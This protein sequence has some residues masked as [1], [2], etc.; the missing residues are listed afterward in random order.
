VFA[1]VLL[2]HGPWSGCSAGQPCRP[3][4][5]SGTCRLETVTK[6]REAE[7]PLPSVVLEAIYRPESGSGPQLL[8]PN[9]RRE[10]V[11]L[12]RYED[13]L[14]AHVMAYPSAL[15]YVNPPPPGQCN[16]GAMVVEVPEFDATRVPAEPEDTGPK[17]CA[18]ID[19]TSTQDRIAREQTEAEAVKERFQ[20]GDGS[21]DLPPEAAAQAET[22]AAR[23]K[24]DP[25]IQCMGVVGQFVKGENLE[26]AIA[27]A[28][29]VRQLLIQHGV[30]PER[31]I[32][33]TLDRPMTSGSGSA[34]P[35]S[36]SD[37]RVTLT[38]LLKLAPKP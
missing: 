18:Q 38:V 28:R 17:G 33:F 16:P 10:F 19:E 22:V 3:E 36:A 15:C 31:L 34:D 27:R 4:T 12:A 13:A 23:M 32:T 6:V 35:S 20:F 30:E 2:A 25:S 29:A 24:Q 5:W 11:A 14:R 37:R 9:V 26:L 21:S 8:L 7:L 1:L